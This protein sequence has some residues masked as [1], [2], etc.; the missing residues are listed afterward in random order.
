MGTANRDALDLQAR[1]AAL[2]ARVAALA[3]PALHV[4]VEDGDGATEVYPSPRGWRPVLIAVDGAVQAAPTNYAQTYD[5][6]VWSADFVTAP[7]SVKVVIVE[8]RT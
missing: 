4:R 8:E 7:G 1:I 5:G 3:A 6:D 2:E